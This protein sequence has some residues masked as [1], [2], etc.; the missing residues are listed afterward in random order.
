MGAGGEG[1]GKTLEKMI[2]QEWALLLLLLLL[3]VPGNE[4][5]NELITGT[6]GCHYNGEKKEREIE[7]I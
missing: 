1:E 7:A 6:A 2:N 3:Q 4:R 5:R